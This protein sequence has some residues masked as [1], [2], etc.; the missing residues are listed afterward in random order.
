MKIKN[1]SRYVYLL[2]LLL[3]SCNPT[4][5]NS[6][7]NEYPLIPI[8]Y[9]IDNISNQHGSVWYQIFVRSFVDSDQDKIG[10]F[11]GIKARLPYLKKLGVSGIWLMPIHP[12]PTYH[13]YDVT[14]YKAIRPTHGTI[15][16]FTS[17]TQAA[18]AANIDVIIDFVVNHSS[19]AHPWFIEAK[20]NFTNNT[21]GVPNSYCDFYTFQR[22]SGQITYESTFGGDMPDLNL[23]SPQLRLELID[24]MK[25]WFDRGVDGFRLDATSHFY[26]S[27]AK[28]IEF[29]TWLKSEA[30]KIKEDAYIVGEAWI[31]SYSLLTP[32]Y[33]ST[34]DSFFHFPFANQ[35]GFLVT[36][37]NEKGGQ[38]LANYLN[39]YNNIIKGS[40]PESMDAPFLSNHDMNRSG[41][42]FTID[43]ILR[44]KL[45]AS[46]YL[47]A[48]G[49][50]FIYY[51]E[52]IALKG[53][54]GSE[55]TDA[56]RRLPMI[57]SEFDDGGRTNP[58]PGTTFDLD[59]QVKQ[60]ALDLI[61]LPFSL[62]NH[63]QK[64]ISL[65]NKYA[66]IETADV[67]FVNLGNT[68]IFALEYHQVN[69]EDNVVVV[70]NFDQ[71]AMTIP[72]EGTI[73]EQIN[74]TQVRPILDEGLLTLA[75]YSSVILKRN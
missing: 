7:S 5:S 58:P 43:R 10:D 63:Y 73:L 32:Y 27:R 42:W 26:S 34:T 3:I 11:N 48:P 66:L 1:I 52:E 39:T 16:D 17:F 45:A 20:K 55:L 65:R 23:D 61:D 6:T 18:E 41:T 22:E 2:S 75:P 50:P 46:V 67:S 30:T 74:T 44:Q 19:S 59:T 69:E 47:L 33:Q 24:I 70:H 35:R 15:D 57:W 8:D 40:N 29:L 4:S 38:S 56:N 25:F 68:A 28:N 12:S 9:E 37:I 31:E 54:R 51:G 71:L 60:G 13:G 14:N 72:W 64:V 21:C 53:S 49:R 62:T 36:K